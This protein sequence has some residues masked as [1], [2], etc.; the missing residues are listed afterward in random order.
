MHKPKLFYSSSTQ[1]KGNKKS[2][3]LLVFAALYCDEFETSSHT[4]LNRL[5][6]FFILLTAVRLKV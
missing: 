6:L 1:L 3:R 2:F 5:L 4:L